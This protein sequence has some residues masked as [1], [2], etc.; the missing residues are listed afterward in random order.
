VTGVPARRKAQL[1]KRARERLLDRPRA[2]GGK[3]GGAALAVLHPQ[4]EQEG[5]PG[6]RTGGECRRR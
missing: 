3:H 5:S 2:F 4:F 1:G 6:G